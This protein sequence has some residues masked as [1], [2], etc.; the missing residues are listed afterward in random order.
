MAETLVTAEKPALI[1]VP[2]LAGA[3]P[4]RA[5]RSAKALA[6]ALAA[7]VGGVA[8]VL[9]VL[10]AV[11][12]NAAAEVI[13]C[14]VGLAGAYVGLDRLLRWLLRRRVDT[15]FWA[16][17]A[18]LTVV[19][20]AAVLADALPVA[21][22]RDVSKTLLE[23][24]LLRPDLFSEHPLGTDK[25]GLDLLGGLIYGARVSLIVGIGAAL[26]GMSIGG[27]IGVCAGYF[28]GKFDAVVSLLS[29]SMLAFPPLILLLAMV[30]VLRPSV[31]NVT[32]ALAVLGIPTYIRLARANTILFSQRE[33]VLAARSLGAKSRRVIFRELVPNVALPVVSYALVGV[34]LLIV[35]EASLSFLGLSIQRPN[36]T[37]GNMIA[38]GQ[39]EFDK[40]PHLVFVPGAILFATVY[41]LNRVGDKARTFWDRREGRL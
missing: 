18:W 36:P 7:L 16:C 37:W 35:A 19:G 1:E 40:H 20:L 5:P 28:R 9:I 4:Y 23:P 14:A 24:I 34:A 11:E 41:A 13:A 12:L 32:I 26:I 8:L 2:L 30:A 15:T 10:L 31:R 17:A 3:Q 38:A 39:A 25:Q 33:F 27:T 21:E 29:D 6:A 22:P